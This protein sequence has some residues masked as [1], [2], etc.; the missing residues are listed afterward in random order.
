MGYPMAQGL[1]YTRMGTHIQ[2]STGS[3]K[4]MVLIVKL[5]LRDLCE[6][7]HQVQWTILKRFAFRQRQGS[8]YERF[9][10][11]RLVQERGKMVRRVLLLGRIDL[12]WTVQRWAAFGERE[13]QFRGWDCV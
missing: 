8:A 4:R 5:R 9:C 6:Y 2:G 3:E 11:Q 10:V 1:S 13:V 12:H 7:E